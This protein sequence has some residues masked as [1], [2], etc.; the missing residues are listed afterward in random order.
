M[1]IHIIPNRASSPAVLLRESYR[2]GDRVRK[3]TLANLSSLPMEQVEAIR[4]ILK[5][6]RLASSE[7]LFDVTASSHHG[8]VQAVRLAMKRLGLDT[9]ISSRPCR[10]RDLVVAMVSARVLEPHSKLATTRWWHTTTLPEDLKVAD[11]D[12]DALYQAMD[13]LVERQSKIERKLAARH[14]DEDSLVLYDLSSSYFEGTCCPLA[15]L[16]HNRDGKKGKLQVNYGLVTT[17]GGCPVSVSVYSGNTGDPNTVMP[18]IRKV[19]DEF[20]IKNFVLVGDRGMIGQKLI[21]QLRTQEPIDWITALKT[22]QIRALMEQG[23]IQMSFFDQRNL[24]E[25]THQD[26]PGERLVVCR[27]PLMAERRTRT[28]QSLL[29]ATERE[30][31]KVQRMVARGTLKDEGKI[32][33]RVGRVVNKYK[34]AKLMK[35]EIGDKT[36]TFQRNEDAIA[37][38][39]ALDGLYVIRTSLSPKRLDAADT[40]RSYKLLSNVER[41]FRCMKTID[42]KVRPIHHRLEDRVRVHIF[43]CMLAYY[44]E[45]HM[46]EAWR[47]LLFS[48]EDQEAKKT[49]DPVAPA[50]RSD[51]AM[52]KVHT[53]KLDDGTEVQSFR[54]LLKDLSTIVRNVCRRKQA[55]KNEASFTITTTPNEKQQRALDLIERIAV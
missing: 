12:E 5:G 7:A 23:A 20:G 42:L 38:E 51:K 55:P 31:E 28:R 34:V 36:F 22:G 27:N 52:Q 15:A 18:Q 13:W 24:V 48:D 16:G 2:Q 8:H 11:A 10:E 44:V 3:R 26:Y 49:R 53:H 35:L 30:L 14:L 6:E 39:A 17:R 41:A 25:M 1:H 19:K 9:L 4:R 54:T 50:T 21:D 37:A 46:L 32:G 40:V 43:L 33:V 45:W 29:E 47:E